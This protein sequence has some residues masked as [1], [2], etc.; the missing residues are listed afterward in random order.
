MSEVDPWHAGERAVQRRLGVADRAEERGRFIRDAMP[1]QHREFFAQL[2]FIVLGALDRSGNPWATILSGHPGFLSSPDPKTL[3]LATLPS[4]GDPAAGGLLPGKRVALLGIELPTRR[5]NRMNGR[6]LDVDDTGFTVAVEQSFG[7]C[8]QYIQRRNYGAWRP[9]TPAPA[10]AIAGANGSA[11]GLIRQADTIFVASS[12]APG[13]SGAG[14][15]VD[16]SHRGGL[17]GFVG[18]AGDGAIEIPDYRGNRY[19]NTLGNLVAYPRAGLLF[20][21]FERGDLLQVSGA[22]EVVWDGPGI[23]GFPGAERLWRVKPS[24]MLRRRGAFPLQLGEPEF[25]PMLVG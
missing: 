17:P 3:H 24:Q 18:I 12:T 19:F 1:D 5:R 13:R 6:I 16:V 21:D 4:D 11:T 2:P 7:N 10:E 9:G 25:S 23:G 14:A 15:G 20:I 22:A 8:P